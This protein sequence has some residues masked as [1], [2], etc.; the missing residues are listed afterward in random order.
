VSRAALG[1]ILAL[2]GSPL[3]VQE[4]DPLVGTWVLN[5]AKSTFSPGP[6]PQSES[7]TYVMEEQK[8]TL[9]ARDVTE[10]RT[11]MLVRKEI[12]ATSSGVDADGKA[13]TREWTI[14]YDG[15]D[16]PV[17]GDPDVDMLTL[18]RIDALTVALTLKRGGRVV[19]TGM[20]AISR[21]G[22][23]M[24]VTTNGV[25]AKGQ[26]ISNVAVFDKQ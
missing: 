11:Y 20:Q 19:I 12:T 7:R 22:K 2:S 6:P 15:K 1:I 5:V 10:P 13:T 16:H 3:A 17:T 4:A 14:G 18:T 26:T 21:N 8:T 24:T 25:N 23:V 9:T